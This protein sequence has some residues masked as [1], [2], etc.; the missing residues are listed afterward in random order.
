M[1][2]L[3]EKS[4]GNVVDHLV[5]PVLPD[6][7]SYRSIINELT[8]SSNLIGLPDNTF[9]AEYQQI[10][11]IVLPNQP[12]KKSLSN[13]AVRIDLHQ[14]IAAATQLTA[15]LVV[16]FPP[17]SAHDLIADGIISEG[18]S[19]RSIEARKKRKAGITP[20]NRII[21]RRLD[22]AD[23]DTIPAFIDQV[24]DKSPQTAQRIHEQVL[25]KLNLETEHIYLVEEHYTI[26]DSEL[27]NQ[28][29][30]IVTTEQ[31]PP[32]LKSLH[33]LKDRLVSKI[34]S[35]PAVE[36][37]NNGIK[38]VDRTRRY[39]LGRSTDNNDPVVLYCGETQMHHIHFC[40]H[41]TGLEFRLDSTTN[42]PYI[43]SAETVARFQEVSPLK[44]PTEPF[45]AT[46]KQIATL[47]AL[48]YRSMITSRR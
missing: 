23:F 19:L 11:N 44:I 12:D 40:D 34:Q 4:M 48:I 39:I 37:K 6:R 45:I 2:S 47:L 38:E 24:N 22:P 8:D 25:S 3:Q 7:W 17:V 1:T 41:E 27:L 21:A 36:I 46:N 29:A 20:E 13:L 15:R 30:Q 16:D 5:R 35:Q 14:A 42:P 32:R 43:P 10:P 9:V 18:S 33:Q 31:Q 28:E 26:T